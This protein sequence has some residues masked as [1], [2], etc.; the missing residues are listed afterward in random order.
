MLPVDVLPNQS[1]ETQSDVPIE[2]EIYT[3]TEESLLPAGKT[4][5]D[6]TPQEAEELKLRYRFAPMKPGTYQGITAISG[7]NGSMVGCL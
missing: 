6:L 2:M 5:A 3:I 7:K 4:F 1:V